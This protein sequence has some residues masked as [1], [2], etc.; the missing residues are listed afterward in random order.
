MKQAT[1]IIL[2]IL[3]CGLVGFR[4][5]S[6]QSQDKQVHNE[7]VT[8]STE[9]LGLRSNEPSSEEA[10]SAVTRY[11]DDIDSDTDLVGL[12][13]LASQYSEPKRT[14]SM[15]I[16]ESSHVVAYEFSNTFAGQ[17]VLANSMLFY[18]EYLDTLGSLHGSHKTVVKPISEI[19][20]TEADRDPVIFM[21]TTELYSNLE[22]IFSN[23]NTVKSLSKPTGEIDCSI[24]IYTIDRELMDVIRPVIGRTCNPSD[25][26]TL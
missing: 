3:I 1:I 20:P 12:S 22:D 4:I 14:A 5:G 26:R 2:V 9:E 18:V 16:D 10:I 19:G 7:E 13:I 15:R 23:W 25:L 17:S 24:G 6:L 11:I 8:A 21:G